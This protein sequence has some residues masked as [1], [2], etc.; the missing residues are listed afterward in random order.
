MGLTVN[1]QNKLNEMFDKFASMPGPQAKRE[2][3]T[4]PPEEMQSREKPEN[5][6]AQGPA[7]VQATLED[8]TPEVKSDKKKK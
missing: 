7:P 5:R 1:N 8:E 6:G 3:P 4:P 2:A